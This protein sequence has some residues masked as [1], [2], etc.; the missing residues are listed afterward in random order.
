MA[1][2]ER[3]YEFFDALMQH[4]EAT[5]RMDVFRRLQAALQP[6]EDEPATEVGEIKLDALF[7]ASHSEFPAED[8]ELLAMFQGWL[9]RNWPEVTET[10]AS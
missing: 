7:V 6:Q 8:Q 10:E 3:Q 4:I 2:T 5:G 9:G 1:T